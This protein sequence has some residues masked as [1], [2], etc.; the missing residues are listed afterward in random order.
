MDETQRRILKRINIEIMLKIN[1]AKT[2]DDKL[3]A[4]FLLQKIKEW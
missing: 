1:I 3:N 2:V 4:D